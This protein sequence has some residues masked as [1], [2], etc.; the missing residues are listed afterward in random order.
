MCF[1]LFTCYLIERAPRHQLEYKIPFLFIFLFIL[2]PELLYEVHNVFMTERAVEAARTMQVPEGFNV[3]LFAGEPAITQPIGFCIDD[4]GRLW[5]AEAKN[6][7]DKKAGLNDRI[8]ILEDTDGD[9]RL[10]Q[11]EHLVRFGPPT[12]HGVHGI[13]L[14]PDGALYVINGNYVK[15]PTDPSD[16]KYVLHEGQ[17]ACESCNSGECG[18]RSMAR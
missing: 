4:R 5:V 7:P 3:T 11:H 15:P 1:L 6:Y 18:A 17:E 14:G 8:I 12:E 16:D 9:G 10:D 2:Q 13:R